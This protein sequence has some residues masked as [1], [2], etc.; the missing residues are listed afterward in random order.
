[1]TV[2]DAHAGCYLKSAASIFIANANSAWTTGA[3]VG[4]PILMIVAEFYRLSSQLSVH[5]H[6]RVHGKGYHILCKF[7]FYFAVCGNKARAS[8]AGLFSSCK[9]LHLMQ[10]ATSEAKDIRLQWRVVARCA[11]RP[12]LQH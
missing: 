6:I 12:M 4:E 11:Q 3:R 5:V 9:W 10:V 2:L 8:Q 1:M 7:S